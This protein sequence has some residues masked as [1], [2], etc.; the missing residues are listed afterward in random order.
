MYCSVLMIACYS[1]NEASTLIIILIDLI[2][3]HLQA[4]TGLICRGRYMTSDR[5]P[6]KY[7]FKINTRMLRLVLLRRV[8]ISV[9]PRSAS[10]YGDTER[11]DFSPLTANRF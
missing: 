8:P 1:Y 5:Y 9:S 11:C 6:W 2:I 10:Q 3:L 4:G 7:N